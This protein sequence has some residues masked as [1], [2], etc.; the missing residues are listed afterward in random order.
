MTMEIGLDESSNILVLRK[1]INKGHAENDLYSILHF[2]NGRGMA[3][4]GAEVGS[5]LFNTDSI[6][7]GRCYTFGTGTNPV[8]ITSLTL[9]CTTLDICSVFF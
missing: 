5:E 7:L 3:L 4:N 6:S 1:W 9:P 2:G 8:H